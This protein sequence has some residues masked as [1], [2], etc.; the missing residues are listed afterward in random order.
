MAPA[1]GIPGPN[2]TNVR[3]RKAAAACKSM[4]ALHTTRSEWAI[5]DQVCRRSR[6]PQQ[7]IAFGSF[8]AIE[9]VMARSEED[10]TKRNCT[11]Q[12]QGNVVANNSARRR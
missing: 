5:A 2:K 12:G 11:E 3:L 8:A 1:S 6:T 10:P 9:V 7:L 4:L